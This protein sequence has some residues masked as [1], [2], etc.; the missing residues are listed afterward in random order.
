VLYSGVCTFV[1][2]LW[3]GF[4]SRYAM[5]IAPSLAVLGGIAWDAMKEPRSL[6]GRRAAAIAVSLLA[7]YQIVLVT[8]V[9]PLFAD[10]FGETRIAG[11]AIGEAVRAAP[12]PAY[13][14]HLDT[15]LLFYAKI[16]VQC[17]D[18]NGLAALNPPAWLLIPAPYLEDLTRLR[19]DVRFNV[20]VGPLTEVELTAT[21][22]ERK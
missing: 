8:V 6:P 12:A 3:P 10:R 14:L 15:N 21:R 17:L 9:M 2:V 16:S 5:P 13:C 11:E 4:A 19:P 1:L 18:I 20:V 22:S 7:A